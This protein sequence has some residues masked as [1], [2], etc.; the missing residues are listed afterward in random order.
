MSIPA[1]LLP[2]L[3]VHPVDSL[4]DTQSCLL[5]RFPHQP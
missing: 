2:L 4:G 1:S 5:N 3:S